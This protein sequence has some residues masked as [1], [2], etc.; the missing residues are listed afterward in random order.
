MT[1]QIPGMPSW[2]DMFA[3]MSM[4]SLF[5]PMREIERGV[6]MAKY[7]KRPIE[8]TDYR[9]AIFDMSQSA[10]RLEYMKTMKGLFDKVQASQC[11]I[12]RNELQV[13]GDTWKRYL[14]WFE[15]RKNEKSTTTKVPAD[16]TKGESN[17]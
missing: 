7:D 11:V 12:C 2:G 8:V 10:D 6:E 13:M 16:G 5:P 9:V 1:N 17:G 3:N 15:F 4:P 14:E